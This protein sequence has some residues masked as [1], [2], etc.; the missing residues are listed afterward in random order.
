MSGDAGGWPSGTWAEMMPRW[1]RDGRDDAG[2]W[3]SGAWAEARPAFVRRAPRAP[4]QH[5]SVEPSFALAAAIGR[6][7]SWRGDV[8]R[9]VNEICGGPAAARPSRLVCEGRGRGAIGLCGV[10]TTPRV[11]PYVG[12]S[13]VPVLACSRLRTCACAKHTRQC[14]PGA[15]ERPR[16]DEQGASRTICHTV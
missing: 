4:S 12:V 10:L 7:A 6:M 13:M 3:P 2:G 16:H 5:G 15:R 14:M 1:C 8:G 11:Q 9:P